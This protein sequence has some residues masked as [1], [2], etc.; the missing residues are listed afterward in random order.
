MIVYKYCDYEVCK[1]VCQWADVD[2]IFFIIG[3][4]TF[5]FIASDA[6]TVYL[7]SGLDCKYFRHGTREDGMQFWVLS[8][9]FG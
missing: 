6:R 3:S 1:R 9:N 4:I 5:L 7:I 8:S 2:D